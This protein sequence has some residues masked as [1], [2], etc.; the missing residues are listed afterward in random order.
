[1]AEFT[2]HTLETAPVGS[3][4]ILEGAAQKYGFT[5]NLMAVLAESPTTLKTYGTLAGLFGETSFSPAEQ[6]IISMT[7]SFENGCTYCMAAHSTI[8]N[9]TGVPADVV[10]S[11]R[12]GSAQADAKHEALANF[13]R[14]LVVNRGGSDA[15]ALEAF[16]AAGYTKA[17]ALEVLVGISQKVISN[18]ANSLAQTPV[19]E[20]FAGQAWSK[21]APAGV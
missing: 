9:M 10:E 11:L 20:N 6:Q 18:Y 15:A 16:L 1:M 7:T 3:K 2:P 12:T 14:S 17:Q 13:T 8:S 5:P 19:D 4:P 21:P